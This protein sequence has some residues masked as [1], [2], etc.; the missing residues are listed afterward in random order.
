MDRVL[1]TNDDVKQKFDQKYSQEMKDLKERYTKDL[2][3]MKSNL[4][5][6]YETKTEHLTERK[7]ELDY[8]NTKLEKQ[9]SDKNKAYEEILY[10]FRSMQ[11]KTDEEIG[12]LRVASRG[13]E[14]EV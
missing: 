7:N 12:Y 13:K 4:I 14:D 8:K 11:K 9:L 2:E 5:E 1:N 6:V 3:L 10:E